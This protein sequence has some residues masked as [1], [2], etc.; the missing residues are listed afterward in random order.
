MTNTRYMIRLFPFVLALVAAAIAP[1][2]AEVPLDAATDSFPVDVY[3]SLHTAVHR[4]VAQLA[5][6][7]Q[8]SPHFPSDE[9]IQVS[10]GGDVDGAISDAAEEAV[11]QAF[12]GSAVKIVDPPSLDAAQRRTRQLVVQVNASDVKR[13]EKPK[14]ADGK[15]AESRPASGRVSVTMGGGNLPFVTASARFI[16]K[17]WADDW[18]LYRN[19]QPSKRWLHADAGGLYE[20]ESEALAAAR[21]AAVDAL[22]PIMKETMNANAARSRQP[23]IPVSD[24]WVR[25]RLRSSVTRNTHG[26]LIPD[27]FVQKF[28]RPYG[29]VWH[30]QL[31]I[32]ASTKNLQDLNRAYNDVA[33]AQFGRKASVWGAL[34]GLTVVIMLLYAFLN[35][36]TKGY[37]VWRLRV[38]ALAGV[39]AGVLVV[40]AVT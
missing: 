16:D 8:Q 31:L 24:D 15:G 12:P 25:Q 22:V 40:F 7:V 34:G 10:V 1:V 20:S 19:S 17:P 14:G 18:N 11:K 3:P 36:A 9:G 26:I 39:I 2:R 5:A 6:D 23:A 32:D 35:A 38:L 30:A 37:F 33:D 27:Q 21:R 4:L 13:G 29:D 28:S